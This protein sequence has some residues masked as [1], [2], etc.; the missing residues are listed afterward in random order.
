MASLAHKN[1]LPL[2]KTEFKLK[3]FYELFRIRR[4]EQEIAKRYPEQEM[5]CP[6]HF[7]IG[8]EAIPVG[9]CAHL[10]HEDYALGAHRSHAP[11][12]AKGGNLR[13]F[14]AEL[15][16]KETG[17]SGGRGGSMHLIDLE[18]G[19]LGCVPIVSST[20]PIGVG[21][22]F[23][24]KYYERDAITVLFFGD[25][26]TE[27]GVFY[28]S[29]NFAKLHNLPVLFVC[30]NNFYAI[31]S[32]LETRRNKD[33]KLLDIVKGFNIEVYS[34]DGQNIEEVYEISRNVIDKIRVDNQPRYI[35]FSTF[36]YLENCGP[37]R[38]QNQRPDG[39]IDAWMK[40]DPV[41][42]FKNQ[43]LHDGTI[44]SDVLSEFEIQIENEIA[45]AFEFAKKSPYPSKSELSKKIYKA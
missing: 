14:I 39:E 2:R 26:A 35:E 40:K 9:V 27:E 43:L 6:T 1:Q 24:S 42:L 12:L 41:K 29:L 38:D 19:F 11:Y 3:L 7:S 28:E 32:R 44:D 23:S 25:G 13:K 21:S 30:E 17:C 37:N 18:A 5:R 33:Q 4:I 45:D 20:I 36:R 8:Q 15:Y 22:A 10:T 34:G 16:G 31:S